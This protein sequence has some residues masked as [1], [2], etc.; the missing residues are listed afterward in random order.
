MT[1][2]RASPS[3][4]RLALAELCRTWH[5]SRSLAGLPAELSRRVWEQLKANHAQEQQAA[6]A[7]SGA[8]D[9]HVA[10]VP[11]SLMFPLVR[12]VWRAS[13]VDLS[14]G[15]RWIT[16]ASIGALAYLNGLTSLRLT[17]CR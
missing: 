12:D 8:A 1:F 11:C 14:D 2:V 13:E 9:S 10:P 6:A 3:L 7:A 15:G 16:D 5:P 4:E 17:T